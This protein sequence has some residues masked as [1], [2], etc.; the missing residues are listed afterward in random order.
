MRWLI[1]LIFNLW[2]TNTVLATGGI[3]F[4][5]DISLE[6]AVALAKT[7][8]KHVFI[9]TYAT[10]C[11]PCRKL[12]KTL[13]DP[14]LVEFFNKNFINVRIN[15]DA[16]VHAPEYKD[17]LEVIF[18]PT[19]AIL[20]QNGVIRFKAD[21]ILSKLELLNIGNKALNPNLYIPNMTTGIE[22]DP[23]SN[24][25]AESRG[26]ETIIHVLGKSTKDLPPDLIR[27]EAYFR[28]EFMD[29]SHMEASRRYL[30]TQPDWT[31]PINLRFIVDFVSDVKSKEWEFLILNRELFNQNL[32]KDLVDRSLQ[33][34]VY[35]HLYQGFPRPTLDEAI[36]YYSLFDATTCTQLGYEY[37]LSRSLDECNNKE[38]FQ[39]AETYLSKVNPH[40]HRV[41]YFL[42]QISMDENR[43]RQKIGLNWI[44]EAITLF[45]QDI[46]YHTLA[47]EMY[48][49]TGNHRLA[50]KS[51][52]KAIELAKNL[53]RKTSYLEN[54]KNNLS[55]DSSKNKG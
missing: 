44:E 29:G 53:G 5:E 27:Q 37:V 47:S 26:P 10:W 3:Q 6:E 48:K 33:V 52:D 54:I 4:V 22:S 38:F 24:S 17:K 12:E 16:A 55:S 13:L 21:R 14:D 15:M 34:V 35:N 1:A 25:G 46:E 28:V 31:T 45:P 8:G 51:I 20:N 39:K 32:G 50:E 41:M 36:N 9:E 42:A 7:A 19:I 49:K 40:D 18:L 43:E 11:I 30:A 2:L 23:I